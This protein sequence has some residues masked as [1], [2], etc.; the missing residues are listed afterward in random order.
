LEIT[1]PGS[2]STEEV[3]VALQQFGEPALDPGES[4]PLAV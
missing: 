3:N 1:V 4:A 2:A